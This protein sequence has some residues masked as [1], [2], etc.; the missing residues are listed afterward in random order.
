LVLGDEEEY[1]S[2]LKPMELNKINSF[3]GNILI[4][5]FAFFTQ[6]KVLDTSNLLT[7]YEKMIDKTYATNQEYVKIKK[8]IFGM[9][10]LVEDKF[11]LKPFFK[12]PKLKGN[13]EVKLL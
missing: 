2:T 10:G 7:L 8:Y 12:L 9:S 11:S 13:K 5:H 6:R 3:A 1:I 4:S